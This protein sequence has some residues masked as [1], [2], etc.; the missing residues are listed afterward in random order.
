MTAPADHLSVN[1]GNKR[2]SGMIHGMLLYSVT[3]IAVVFRRNRG[4]MNRQ[5][6]TIASDKKRKALAKLWLRL[7]R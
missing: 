7:T 5:A 3:G 4:A 6:Q 1:V 2:T